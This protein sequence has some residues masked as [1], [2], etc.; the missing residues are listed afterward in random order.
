MLFYFFYVF[1]VFII[2][3]FD[4]RKVNLFLR[5]FLNIYF[6]GRDGLFLEST[7]LR[8][9]VFSY[10]DIVFNLDV[11]DRFFLFLVFI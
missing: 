8:S 11:K 9:F 5:L 2:K 10:I 3:G 4:L 1:M 6:I 7:Y